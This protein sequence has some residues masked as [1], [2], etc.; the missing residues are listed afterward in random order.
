MLRNKKFSLVEL[1]VVLSVIAVLASLLLPV[2]N[3]S[4]ATARRSECKNNLRS[5]GQSVHMYVNAY[6]GMLPVACQMPSVD[7]LGLPKI[8]DVLSSDIDNPQA[9]RCPSDN[10]GYFEAEGSS[11][12]YNMNLSGQTIKQVSEH[13]LKTDTFV[14]FD[15]KPF[16]GKAGGAGST[17]YLF[18]DGRV[19]DLRD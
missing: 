17:N 16:H 5:L 3:S 13:F 19:D 14:M 8:S 18:I 15:F 1:L 11:Y 12:E 7:T 10:H 4:R 9:F 6:D 2:V